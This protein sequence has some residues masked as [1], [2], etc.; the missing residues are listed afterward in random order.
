MRLIK[1][2]VRGFRSLG[3]VEVNFDRL[4]MLIGGNDTGKSSI[5]DLLDIVLNNQKPDD[6][7][8][9]CPPGGQACDTIEVILEF[10]LDVDRDADARE[11]AVGDRLRVLKVYTSTSAETFYWGEHPADDRLAQDFEKMLAKDQKELIKELDPLALDDLTNKSQR[12][13]WLRE[14]AATAPQAQEW[15]SVPSRW[16]SFLPRFERYSTMDYNAPESMILQTLRQVYEGVVYEEKEQ[17]GVVVRQPVEPLRD[18]Q[19]EVKA[20]IDRKVK[21]LLDYI[22][23][24]NDRVWNISFDPVFDFSGGLRAGGQFQID[25]G[26]GLRYLSK[27]GDGTKRRMFIATLDWDREVTLEQTAESSVVSLDN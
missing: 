7:D 1:L 4:T 25:D 17:D 12:A 18:I 3:Q 20:K 26:R 9:H 6:D 11:Y 19:T 23:R 24:Y 13:A 8:F 21:E 2:E 14:Y 15:I 22:K 5:L 16:G 10:H 27:T